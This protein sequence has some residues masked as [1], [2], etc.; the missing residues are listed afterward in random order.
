MIESTP[1]G[2]GIGKTIRFFAPLFWVAIVFTGLVMLFNG[3]VSSQTRQAY[4]VIKTAELARD[5]EAL[6]SDI[7]RYYAQHDNYYG[8]D[9]KGSHLA[10]NRL[11]APKIS[12]SQSDGYMRYLLTY[13]EL[14]E[15]N[16]LVLG[17]KGVQKF[18]TV[19][20]NGTDIV[21]WFKVIKYCHGGD[22]V[23]FTSLPKTV[24]EQP[25]DYHAADPYLP[26]PNVQQKAPI[27]TVNACRFLESDEVLY[28]GKQVTIVTQQGNEWY[29]IKNEYGETMSKHKDD[30]T[31]R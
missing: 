6:F 2:E 22:D 19:N 24:S 21:D 25:E 28:Q 14:S 5:V 10:L 13:S 9:E 17:I 27:N 29:R 12:S 20:V 8:I 31:C 16:C 7:E 3:F 18:S 30:L 4:K 11:V 23:R 26:V 1:E 15:E